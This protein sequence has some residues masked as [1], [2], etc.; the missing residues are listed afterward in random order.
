[1]SNDAR[2]GKTHE[3]EEKESKNEAVKSYVMMPDVEKRM[4]K[5]RKKVRMK[6]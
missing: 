4:K 2:C 3:K 5:K 6:R 1:M